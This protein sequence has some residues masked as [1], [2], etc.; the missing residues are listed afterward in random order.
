MNTFIGIF[1]N[2]RDAQRA[3]GM[4]HDSRYELDD[5]S[6]IT[7]ASEHG[8]EVNSGDDVSASEGATVGAVWG[9]LVGLASLVIPGVGPFIAGGAL[10]T[11]LASAA[12]GAVTGAVV[13]GVAAALIQ[14]GGI[15][16]EDAGR[17]ESL[18]HAGKTLVAVKARA[19]DARHVHRILMKADAEEVREAGA[20]VAAAPQ[21]PVQVA[22]YDQQGRR[23][24]VEGQG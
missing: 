6:I 12:A 19:E 21:S 20:A 17:Y 18:V 22:M 1:D 24:D 3:V 5:V 14:F 16:E 4:L 10:A 11:A 8:V 23:V 9:G 7:R 2:P 13:G 15:S